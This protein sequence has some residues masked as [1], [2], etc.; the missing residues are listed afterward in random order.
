MLP[1]CTFQADGI[2]GLMCN[3]DDLPEQ[4]VVQLDVTG[5]DAESMAVVHR[6]D[7]LL[8]Q[9]AHSRLW[10]WDTLQRRRC[11]SCQAPTWLAR[12]KTAE[13]QRRGHAVRAFETLGQQGFHCDAVSKSS[14]A[15]LPRRTSQ[16]GQ[17][18]QQSFV[19][20]GT[21]SRSHLSLYVMVH[22]PRHVATTCKVHDLGQ[23]VPASRSW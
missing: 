18:S 2:I 10:K 14:C 4:H 20:C 23:V 16:A 22:S 8:D 17:G 12:E 13:V 5:H 7:E 11:R 19:S 15:R 9:R 1:P 3:A 6:S 21:H